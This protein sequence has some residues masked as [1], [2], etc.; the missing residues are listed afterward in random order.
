[1][2]LDTI[3]TKLEILK[4]FVRLK[5]L[6][7]MLL[8]VSNLVIL[9]LYY[10]SEKQDFR[11][12]VTYLR[13]QLR[14]GDNIIV[15]TVALF[16]GLLHYFGVYPAGRHYII[17]YRRISGDE[18]EHRISLM[19]QKQKFIISCS[20]TYWLQYAMEGKRLWIVANKITAKRE[21][22]NAVLK[23]Y[24]D[25]SFLNFNR[26]PTDDSMYLFLWDPKSPNEKGIDMPIE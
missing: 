2:S 10:R 23:G 5:S 3:E 7:I 15:S 9:P 16:P 17:P 18:I 8:V 14:D 21:K 19:N 20:K 22:G 1:M 6:F 12:L 24:F 4:K 26:F 25:A 11:G 13:G